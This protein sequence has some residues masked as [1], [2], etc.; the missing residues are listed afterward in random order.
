MHGEI[1]SQ[2]LAA[3]LAVAT[4]VQCHG[5]ERREGEKG[6]RR[7]RREGMVRMKPARSFMALPTLPN[8]MWVSGQPANVLHSA[9]VLGVSVTGLRV[10]TVW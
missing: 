6:A 4:A 9:L 2:Q 3:V 8:T 1:Q 7:E 5:D 10:A